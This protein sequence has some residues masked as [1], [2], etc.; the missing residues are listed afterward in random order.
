MEGS[1]GMDGVWRGAVRFAVDG[2]G[3][4]EYALVLS[5]DRPDWK[6]GI[7]GRR[8]EEGKWLH[9]N[10]SRGNIFCHKEEMK[11]EAGRSLRRK[12]LKVCFCRDART[13][14]VHQPASRQCQSY[15]CQN[16][17]DMSRHDCLSVSPSGHAGIN[18]LD[19]L[20]RASLLTLSPSLVESLSLERESRTHSRTICIRNAP[21]KKQFCGNGETADVVARIQ[22]ASFLGDLPHGT[23]AKLWGLL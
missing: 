16:I 4:S 1:L 14:R 9:S 8:S 13:C 22:S 20:K 6:R 18:I 2:K 21:R 23:F 12:A 19:I 7:K 5:A 11:S 17:S 15:G 10:L 3:T